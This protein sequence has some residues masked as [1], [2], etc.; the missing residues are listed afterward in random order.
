MRRPRYPYPMNIQVIRPPVQGAVNMVRPDTD[1]RVGVVITCQDGSRAIG[2]HPD[3][4]IAA[5]RIAER[6]YGRMP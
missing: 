5:H 3:S 6:A 4:A 1:Y 2:W